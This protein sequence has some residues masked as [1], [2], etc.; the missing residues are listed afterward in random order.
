M[1]VCT[2]HGIMHALRSC[3]MESRN[4]SGYDTTEWINICKYLIVI[5]T[6]IYRKLLFI[7]MAMIT[8]VSKAVEN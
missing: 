4:D 7:N 1:G 5:M 2:A 8:V 6:V 3:I